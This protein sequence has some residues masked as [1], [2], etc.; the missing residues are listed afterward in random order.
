LNREVGGLALKRGDTEPVLF[1][2]GERAGDAFFSIVE[3]DAFARLV[4]VPG[5]AAVLS[6]P[7][8]A[9]EA[10]ALEIEGSALSQLELG[11]SAKYES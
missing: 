1:S 4:P 10:T 7:A 9:V 6:A 2:K 8:P 11:D 3:T 5:S